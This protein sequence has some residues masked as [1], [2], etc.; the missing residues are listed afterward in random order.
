MTFLFF[1]ALVVMVVGF[2]Q[3]NWLALALSVP[4]FIYSVA[5]LDERVERDNRLRMEA[6]RQES[7][8]RG[9]GKP[10]G[11]VRVVAGDE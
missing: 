6:L 10:H 9:N 3:M 7:I 2:A 4:A 1:G 11:S 8:A 5:K